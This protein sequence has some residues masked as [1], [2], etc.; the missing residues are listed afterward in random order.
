MKAFP[1]VPSKKPY[2]PP[3]LSKYGDLAMLTLAAGPNFKLMDG[4]PNNTKSS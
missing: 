4:G 3:R 2:A 1:E